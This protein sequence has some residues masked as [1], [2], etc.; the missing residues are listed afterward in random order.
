[1]SFY[2]LSRQASLRFVLCLS[3]IH[4]KPRL[5]RPRWVLARS[6]SRRPAAGASRR[7]GLAPRAGAAG[8]TVAA[9]IGCYHSGGSNTI[10]ASAHTLSPPRG[11]SVCVCSFWPFFSVCETHTCAFVTNDFSDLSIYRSHV[12]QRTMCTHVAKA[13]FLALCAL[14]NQC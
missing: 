13:S 12:N 6:S 2:A 7:L 1:L 10:S 9:T 4:S 3:A 8:G 14:G 11:E 5:C